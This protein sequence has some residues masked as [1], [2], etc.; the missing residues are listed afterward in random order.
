[1]PMAADARRRVDEDI[2]DATTDPRLGHGRRCDQQCVTYSITGGNADGLFEIDAGTGEVSLATGET[3]DAELATSHVLTVRRATDG[4]GRTP[5]RH[6]HGD[7]CRRVRP[8]F[9]AGRHIR[10]TVAENLRRHDW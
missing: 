1:M 5:R 3:L 6:H 10:P 4:S 2:S 9:D 8:V 7:R